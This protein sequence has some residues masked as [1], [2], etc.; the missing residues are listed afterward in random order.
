MR[1]SVFNRCSSRTREKL[2]KEFIEIMRRIKKVYNWM[3]CKLLGVAVIND[4]NAC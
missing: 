3:I 2:E 1:S 4:K